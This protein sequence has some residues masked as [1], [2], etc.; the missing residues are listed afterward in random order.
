MFKKAFSMS[1]EKP[2]EQSTIVTMVAALRQE[3]FFTM[4]DALRQESF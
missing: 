4:T 2:S 3:S 1:P